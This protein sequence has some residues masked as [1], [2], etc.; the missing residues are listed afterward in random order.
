MTRFHVTLA[1]LCIG[2]LGC[3]PADQS[4]LPNSVLDRPLDLEIGCFS[5]DSAT[6]R[7][8]AEPLSAC[9]YESPVS[10]DASLIVPETPQMLGFVANSERNEVALVRRCDIDSGV[11]DLDPTVPGYNLLSV[12]VLPSFMTA[13]EQACTVIT[14]NAGSCD[15]TVLDGP[16]VAAY[17]IDGATTDTP[18]ALSS[19]VVPRRA[20]GDPLE[21]RPGDI[22]AVPSELSTA[23][24]AS[25]P[26]DGATCGGSLEHSVYVVFPACQ[27]VAEISLATQEVLQ[28]RRFVTSIGENGEPIVSIEDAGLNPECPLE[29]GGGTGNGLTIDPEGFFPTTLTLSESVDDERLSVEYNA[30]FIGGASDTLFEIP[31]GDDGV[32]ATPETTLTLDLEAAEGVSKVR[33]TPIVDMIDGPRQFLYV[34]ADDGTT[35]VVERDPSTAALG[36]ECDTQID[37]TT[38]RDAPAS[39]VPVQADTPNRRPSALGPGIQAEQG[40]IVD[41]LFLEG[42]ERPF[43]CDVDDE[44]EGADQDLDRRP[45]C[46][47]H[48]VGVG[49]TSAGTVIFAS[50]DGYQ[51]A[52][53]T[54]DSLDPLG[55]M[56]LTVTPHALWPSQQP[57]RATTDSNR[58]ALPRVDD[59]ETEFTS[60]GAEDSAQALSPALRRIDYAYATPPDDASVSDER[61]ELSERLGN[62]T[63][64]DQLGR[65]NDENALYLEETPRVITRDYRS[66]TAVNQSWSLVWEGAIPGTRSTTGRIECGAEAAGWN[67]ALCEPGSGSSLVDEGARFCESGVLPG[68][69][70]I[71]TG[72]EDDAD[73]GV[74]QRCLT[75]STADAATGICVSESAFNDN[76]PLLTARCRPFITDP[77]GAPRRE[78]L[79]TRAF[80]DRLELQALDLDRSAYVRDLNASDDD[81]PIELVEEISRYTCLPLLPGATGEA[82]PVVDGFIEPD[83]DTGTRTPCNDDEDCSNGSVCTVDGLCRQCAAGDA[84]ACLNCTRDADCEDD[85]GPDAICSDNQCR[86]PCTSGDSACTVTPLPGNLCFAELTEYYVRSDNSFIVR[87]D[88]LDSFL[89]DRVTTRGALGETD[90]ELATECVEDPN[91]SELLNSRIPLGETAEDTWTR[92]RDPILDCPS[93]IAQPTDPNP[94]RVVSSTP[95][96]LAYTRDYFGQTVEAIRY[97]NPFMSVVLDLVNLSQLAQTPELVETDD[98]RNPSVW[99]ETFTQFRRARIPS[100]Y[101]ESFLARPG[102]D[103]LFELPYVGTVPLIF[104]VQL[105]AGAERNTAYIVDAGGRGGTL[106]VRGQVVRIHPEYIGSV[107]IADQ[108]FRVR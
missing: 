5:V 98:L 49:I 7:V 65:F 9:D 15:L 94:C 87:G 84:N 34:V 89:T 76:L 91:V 33:P 37:P 73:C 28:S 66:W 53:R 88:P 39:C 100:G 8:V 44:E 29:C 43:G 40:A 19:T 77:C 24:G 57:T 17:G 16:G 79:V 63:N 55:T 52:P 95:T 11:V 81:A 74:G 78:F 10:C 12:G 92:E 56:D 71:L 97:S 85:F 31:I 61:R 83:A 20:N 67:G 25:L 32:W 69:V 101:S 99:P 80:Q 38:V 70:L 35:R 4:A 14:S 41:W 54:N 82:S 18:G 6:G 50:L 68:D 103:P 60:Q 21:A 108:T 107:T 93:D 62:P 47:E 96:D 3:Q 51:D 86:R 59:R 2:L 22:L 102:Y 45:F 105:V 58:A 23:P 72:C 104:P 27:L 46:Q 30:L 48:T 26:L 42:G 64:D 13:T 106:G 36:F 75:E 90:P 1:A